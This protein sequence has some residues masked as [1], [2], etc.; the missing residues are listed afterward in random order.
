MLLVPSEDKTLIKPFVL[1]VL[2][3]HELEIHIHSVF[4]YLLVDAAGLPHKFILT[5]ENISTRMETENRPCI[6][7]FLN[8]GKLLNR[9]FLLYV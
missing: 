7:F 5:G 1:H 6:L 4:T 8:P 3:A 9:P 2:F